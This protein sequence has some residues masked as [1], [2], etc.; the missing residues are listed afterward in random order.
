MLSV[1]VSQSMSPKCSPFVLSRKN[2]LCL[3][4]ESEALCDFSVSFS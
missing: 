3:S 4:L 1:D 2:I